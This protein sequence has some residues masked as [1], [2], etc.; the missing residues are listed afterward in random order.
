MPWSSR[1]LPDMI[2]PTPSPIECHPTWRFSYSSSLQKP[3]HSIH[4]LCFIAF[5]TH[6]SSARCCRV[7]CINYILTST[8]PSV[9]G[10]RVVDLVSDVVVL[11]SL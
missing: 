5:I 9:S 6:N 4:S 7:A 1:L 8:W 2:W 10:A 11:P 3:Y